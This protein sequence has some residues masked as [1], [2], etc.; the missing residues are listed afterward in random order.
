MKFLAFQ[1]FV[2]IFPKQ[3]FETGFVTKEAYIVSFLTFG[4]SW[5]AV[6][7]SILKGGRNIFSAIQQFITK[8]SDLVKTKNVDFT[9][10]LT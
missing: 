4:F 7:K 5:E 3:Q 2:T 1:W 9:L 6:Q 10:L 8:N